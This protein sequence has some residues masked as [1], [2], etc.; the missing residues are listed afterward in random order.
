VDVRI[1]HIVELENDATAYGLEVMPNDK[2]QA[3]FYAWAGQCG[4]MD[5]VTLHKYRK[6]NERG[7]Q[8]LPAI[9]VEKNAP[10]HV[11]TLLLLAWE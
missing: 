2:E 6:T 10:E 1:T 7:I 3:E 4:L 9:L 11:K 8:Y 5:H